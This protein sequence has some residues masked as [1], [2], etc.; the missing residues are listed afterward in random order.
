MKEKITLTNSQQLIFN[1]LL[2]FV[3]SET[4]RVFILKGYAGTGKTTLMR[5]L[6]NELDKRSR[7]YLLLASTGRAA[8]ILSNL[9]GCENGVSTIHGLIYKFKDF[10]KDVSKTKNMDDT[11]Q[12]Y[13]VFEPTTINED[14]APD[15]IY[16]VDEAS[17]V[18]DVTE[19]DIT[20]ASF[21]SGRLLNELLQYDS[22][23][24]SKFIFIGDPCQLPPINQYFSPALMPAYFKEIFNIETQVGELTEIMRQQNNNSI[25]LASK[26]IRK[27]YNNAPSTDHYGN[28][29]VWGYLPLRNCHDIKLYPNDGTMLDRY[30]DTIQKNGYNY[31]TFIC[32]SNA[33]CGKISATVRRRL[34][35]N[36]LRVQ[37][38]DL[39]LVIQNNMI[40]GL[41][42]G[43]MVTVEEVEKENRWCAGLSFRKATVRELFT[44][45]S[46]SL[47]LME[48]T[49][50]LNRLNLDSVQQT[51]L[52]V[53]FIKRMDKLGIKPKTET[54]KQ[55]MW[56]D[57]YLNALRCVYG[58][59]ITCHKAQGG[60]WDDVFINFTQ[61][62]FT[63]NP[64]KSTYQWIYTAM[65]RAKRTLHIIDDFYIK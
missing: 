6:I 4:D 53:D 55:K 9:T 49:I 61:R 2:N 51:A 16:I 26:K 18:S 24:R 15:F 19:K 54:F 30:I 45:R 38:G 34:N 43:D 46:Y 3:D 13:L 28:Q 35:F 40:C 29:K 37:E 41:M 50:Y 56:L 57:P 63:M 17:M 33:A 44:K 21:G 39:L 7:Q 62:N 23:P 60:E 8:K 64:T 36:S 52:Y 10:N 32:R 20:Q 22:R 5:F 65:T 48:D 59:A 42:N 14:T 12:L 1:R 58:Y 27:L 11:G 31:A 47:L 25:V